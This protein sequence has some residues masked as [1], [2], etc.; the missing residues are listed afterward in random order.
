MGGLGRRSDQTAEV[1]AHLEARLEADPTLD[2]IVLGD[3]NELG[4]G[5]PLRVLEGD[6]VAPRLTNLTDLLPEEERYSFLFEG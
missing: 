3:L 5:E 1:R 6:G 4:F 2:V